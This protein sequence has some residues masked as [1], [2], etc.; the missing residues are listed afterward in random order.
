MPGEKD[1]DEKE[2]DETC[3]NP[4]VVPLMSIRSGK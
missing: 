2:K 1:K 3:G 4:D